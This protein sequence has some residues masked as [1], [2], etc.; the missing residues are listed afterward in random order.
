MRKPKRHS[1]EWNPPDLGDGKAYAFGLTSKEHA[2]MLGA[3]AAAFEHLNSD[4]HKLLALLMGSGDERL[5]AY[6][7][8]SLISA[9]ARI[10]LMRSLLQK[11][12]NN[13]HLDSKYDMYISEFEGI[14]AERNAYI[15]GLWYTQ[16]QD[17]SVLL[18]RKDEHGLGL[19]QSQPVTVD[20]LHELLSRIHRLVA[21][22]NAD[23]WPAV[24]ALRKPKDATESKGT[25]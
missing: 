8:R 20:E 19:F 10:Q 7:Y 13:K 24:V 25:A 14:A 23:V 3:I 4:M 5:P 12:P 17:Q 11:A 1:I 15:H 21:I 6:I 16:Q 18:A 22:I 9:A 2:A